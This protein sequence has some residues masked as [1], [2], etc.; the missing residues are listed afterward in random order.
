MLAQD[1]GVRGFTSTPEYMD[2]DDQQSGYGSRAAY[3]EILGKEHVWL[4]KH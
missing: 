1:Q 2:V 4:I 3:V